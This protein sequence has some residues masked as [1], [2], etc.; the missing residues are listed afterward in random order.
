MDWRI[1][2]NEMLDL[3][4]KEKPSA[5]SSYAFGS[6]YLNAILTG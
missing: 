3:P 2:P 4:E 1:L 5:F 6:V